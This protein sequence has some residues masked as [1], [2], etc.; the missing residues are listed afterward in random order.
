MIGR[1]RIVRRMRLLEQ[2]I[3]ALQL[4]VRLPA[5]LRTARQIATDMHGPG[6]KG[7]S[8][9]HQLERLERAG[10]LARERTG[11]GAI[12]WRPT[13]LGADL[14]AKRNAR[15]QDRVR[16]AH[17]RSIRDRQNAVRARARSREQQAIDV[18][19]SIDVAV[20]GWDRP[21][22]L[23]SADYARDVP[24][25]FTRVVRICRA[26]KGQR[27]MASVFIGA[28]PNVC[29]PVTVIGTITDVEEE[30]LRPEHWSIADHQKN[31]RSTK[32]SA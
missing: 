20:A 24:I 6:A 29:S 25:M 12:L 32:A 26:L 14:L 4:V 9:R 10:A 31:L 8:V 19:E 18:W 11:A 15:D 17:L 13:A 28:T 27:L 7:W 2:D 16:R 21:Q 23:P 3:A 22:L 30:C 1:L 5:P